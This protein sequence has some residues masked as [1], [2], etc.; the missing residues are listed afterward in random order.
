MH[1]HIHTYLHALILHAYIHWSAYIPTCIHALIA[2]NV[3]MHVGMYAKT[4][5]GLFA[6]IGLLLFTYL[7][8]LNADFGNSRCLFF[9]GSTY[10]HT[11]IH[12]HIHIHTCIHTYIHINICAYVHALHTNAHTQTRVR[13]HTHRRSLS[14]TSSRV[15]RAR[16]MP[17]SELMIH[18]LTL[19]CCLTRQCQT[20]PNNMQKRPSNTPKEI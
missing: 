7:S 2:I 15:M 17:K 6:G 20:R 11:H 19:S 8:S 9:L 16:L 10:I 18:R 14:M 3:C 4:P 12:T 13:A 1:I 5:P